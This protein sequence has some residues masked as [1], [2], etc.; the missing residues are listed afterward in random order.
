MAGYLCE[1]ASA[2][3]ESLNDFQPDHTEG[4]VSLTRD[5]QMHMLVDGHVDPAYL[6]QTCGLDHLLTKYFNVNA[7]RPEPDFAS[8]LGNPVSVE[9]I[10]RRY[11]G[12]LKDNA[13][14]DEVRAAGFNA[15]QF[16]TYSIE[17]FLLN[18]Y[19]NA[20]ATKEDIIAALREEA[21]KVTSVQDQRESMG[22]PPNGP[23]LPAGFEPD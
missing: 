22:I 18:R 17:R 9:R 6:H 11:A 1:S 10:D 19:F 7:A 14:D 16:D 5:I 21:G 13:G 8:V 2:A 3:F 15:G 23:E 12:F 20:S 4:P